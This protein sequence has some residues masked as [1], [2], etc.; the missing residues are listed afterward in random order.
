M[1]KKTHPSSRS[2]WSEDLQNDKTIWP[3]SRA[4]LGKPVEI[5]V[6]GVLWEV[7]ITWRKRWENSH[8]RWM[9]HHVELV[10]AQYNVQW[11]VV[12]FWW[13]RQMYWELVAGLIW[14]IIC[15]KLCSVCAGAFAH[16]HTLFYYLCRL[17][18]LRCFVSHLQ[19]A[20]H[21]RHVFF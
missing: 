7:L 12:Y 10:G 11:V 2:P 21:I 14:L 19:S 3:Q 4:T 20:N 1:V 13:H 9:H 15:F 17:H 8:I 16:H 5:S 18:W 6:G